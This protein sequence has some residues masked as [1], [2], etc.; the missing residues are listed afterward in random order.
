MPVV[1]TA[2]QELI[3]FD[4]ERTSGHIAAHCT[5]NLGIVHLFLYVTYLQYAA[6]VSSKNLVQT[7]SILQKSCTYCLSKTAIYMLIVL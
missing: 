6:L 5:R 4:S 2:F 7:R 3:T 1:N